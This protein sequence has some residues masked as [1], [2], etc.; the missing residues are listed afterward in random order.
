[1]LLSQLIQASGRPLQM[2]GDDVEIDRLTDDSRQAGP[3]CL[4]AATRTGRPYVDISV[5][6]GSPALL[7]S[8]GM[9]APASATVITGPR[10]PDFELGHLAAALYGHASQKLHVVAVTGTNGKTTTTHMLYHIWKS[11]G[12]SAAIV[13]TLGVRLFDGHEERVF[14]TGFTTPRSYELHRLLREMVDAGIERVAM[15]ASS[16]ALSLGRMEGLRP[17]TVLFTGFGRDHLD[18][19]HTLAAYLRAK[20]HLFFLGLRNSEA[21]FFVYREDSAEFGLER[22]RERTS[23]S[24]FRWI[25][26]RDLADPR[27]LDQFVP[28]RFNRINAILALHAAERS[29]V[30]SARLTG[31]RGVPG[32]M[33]HV[34]VSEGVDA[35]VDYAHSPDAM[36]RVLAELRG[37]GY[38]RIVVVFGCGGDRDAGKRPIMGEIAARLSD[39]AIITDDNPRSEDPRAIRAQ[40]RVGTDRVHGGAAVRD[41]L[42][43]GGGVT[44][45]GDRSEAIRQGVEMALQMATQVSAAGGTSSRVPGE[46]VA[47]AARLVALVVAGKGHE[48]YQIIGKEKR[49]FSDREEIEKCRE[50]RRFPPVS[51]G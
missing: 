34:P 10:R 18:Y 11:A 23:A 39:A 8:R 24:R 3:G 28:T 27:T 37:I 16:E 4:F 36:E 29:G 44:E 21:A 38:Q 48:D 49:H 1:M 25:D 45:T 26:D 43:T 50:S 17:D 14:Q 13:G 51:S 20:R 22:F 40:I 15:E 32:R 42:E 9:A 46:R 33:E 35:F 12:L 19:H 2:R 30:P 5:R 47:H 6:S 41:S 31:F 7:L